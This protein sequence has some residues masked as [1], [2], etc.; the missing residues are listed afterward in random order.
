MAPR[1]AHAEVAAISAEGHGGIDSG[2][3]SAAA[4]SAGSATGIGYR[5]GARLLIFE[6]YFD[7]TTF[8]QGVNVSRGILGVRGGFGTRSVRLVLR[9]GGGVIEEEGGALTGRLP[10][11]PERRGVVGR[12]GAAIEGRVAPLFL[13]GFGIDGERFAFPE[14]TAGFV[15]GATSGSSV[16]AKLHLMFEL[17]I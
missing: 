14:S 5:L 7:Y 9:A 12:V 2:G 6:G 17:G 16:F 8:G 3:S 1:A 13:V 11:T 10:G 15:S 4:N